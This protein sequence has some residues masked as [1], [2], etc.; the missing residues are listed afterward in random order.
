MSHLVFHH[1]KDKYA[2]DKRDM[3]DQHPTA[4]QQKDIIRSDSGLQT[5]SQD[6]FPFKH[7]FL[8][9][10]VLLWN[11]SLVT[12]HFPVRLGRKAMCVMCGCH[13]PLFSVSPLHLL[14]SSSTTTILVQ[15]SIFFHLDHCHNLLSGLPFC[16]FLC[17]S[18]VHSTNGPE[19]FAPC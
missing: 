1:F 18:Q 7:F 16:C 10:H 12:H 6:A 15:A 4:Y 2:K 11:R 13:P 14:L 5:S 8:S 17:P 3:T 9:H 19:V